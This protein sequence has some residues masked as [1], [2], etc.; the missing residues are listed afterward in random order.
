M[1]EDD[2]IIQAMDRENEALHLAGSHIGRFEPLSKLPVEVPLRLISDYR[3]L[4]ASRKFS[5][6]EMAAIVQRDLGIAI[7]RLRGMT[8]GMDHLN[9]V[10]HAVL[11]HVAVMIGVDEL[12]KMGTLWKALRERRYEDAATEL[13]LSKWPSVVASDPATDDK[14]RVVELHRMMWTGLL[15]AEA[16][17]RAH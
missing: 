7:V 17:T 13:L 4:L 10:R 16:G 14:Q 5:R 3:H 15:P 6:D 12:A 2:L 1:M 8:L 11:L 9:S